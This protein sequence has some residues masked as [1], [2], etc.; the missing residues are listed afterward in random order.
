MASQKLGLAMIAGALLAIFAIGAV[1]TLDVQKRRSNEIRADGV[2]L[3]R[4]LGSFSYRELGPEAGSVSVLES[5]RTRIGRSALAYAAVVDES[6][7][8]R[9]YVGLP[10][11]LDGDL[12]GTGQNW[13]GE[14]E[15]V[16]ADGRTVIEF[17]SPVTQDGRLAGSLRI[18][19]LK[20]TPTVALTDI[21]FLAQLAL[22]VFLLIPLFY[23]LVRR[24]M[25]PLSEVS[26]RLD[27][28]TARGFG[29][30]EGA[31]LTPSA[32]LQA[33]MGNFE[34]FLKLADSRV[35]E[36]KTSQ[37]DQLVHQRLLSYE[38]GRIEAALQSI[39]DG[40]L[41]IDES[42]QVSFIND[43][44][45]LM[46]GVTRNDALNQAISEWCVEASVRDFLSRF[47]G[48]K[49]L[50]RVETLEFSP[51]S[52]PDKTVS[53]NAFPLFSPKERSSVF[54]AVALFRDVTAEIL[55]R[56]AR[57]DQHYSGRGRSFGAYG[58]RSSQHHAD[59]SRQHR[60]RSN[61]GQAART[62]GRCVQS[63]DARRGCARRRISPR[64]ATQPAHDSSG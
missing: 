59:R 48:G 49:S 4:L 62:A 20:P 10:G 2:A 7:Q 25:S 51:A 52:N 47:N 42:G 3:A 34:R 43:N 38:K 60:Y 44:L 17:D 39:P 18:G 16:I 12:A 36:A 19:F 30:A 56:S 37:A 27:E 50:H 35:Q 64:L 32:D 6:G 29:T 5:L 54:G 45:S 9:A 26:R 1:F 57:D 31:V 40:V 46:L 53:V 61:T 15:S 11:A 55:A 13:L 8:V 41:V 14:R 22:P 58:R 63:D 33:F 24:E 23:Y 21:S 28:V